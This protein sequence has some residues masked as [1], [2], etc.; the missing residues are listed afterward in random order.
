MEREEARALGLRSYLTGQPCRKG[1]TATRL[2]STGACSECQSA[3]FISWHAVNTDRSRAVSA[4]YRAKHKTEAVARV[5][6]WRVDNPGKRNANAREAYHKDPSK[7]R[8]ASKRWRARDPIAAREP[9]KKWRIKN[10]KKVKL[11]DIRR[12]ARKRFAEGTFTSTDLDRI[13]KMQRGCCAYCRTKLRGKYEIDHIV[14]LALGGSNYPNNIQ[15]L[16]DR[17][18]GQACNQQKS[19]M[20]PIDFART[21]GL[22]L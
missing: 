4:A 1:H 9:Q 16:C 17:V 10:P 20:D 18:D 22:L 21:R 2:V 8:E 15:L 14:P 5:R 3:N 19:A 13:Y 12:R 6:K 11:R 7:Q